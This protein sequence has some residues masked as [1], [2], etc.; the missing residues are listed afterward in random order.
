MGESKY[1]SVR[2]LSGGT[3]VVEPE[4]EKPDTIGTL[5]FDAH[6]KYRVAFKTGD[7]PC[8]ITGATV[9]LYRG[10]KLSQGDYDNI[11]HAILKTNEIVRSCVSDMKKATDAAKQSLVG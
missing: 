2:A 5:V 8:V 4:V 6:P 7:D 10:S 9:K 3:A 11:A 1:V